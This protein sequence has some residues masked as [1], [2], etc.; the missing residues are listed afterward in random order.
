MRTETG[1]NRRVSVL[2][3]TKITAVVVAAAALAMALAAV[4]SYR[5]VSDLVG[6]ELERGL[7]DRMH[8]VHTLVVA[9][10]TPPPRRGIADQVV[11]ERGTVRR[12]T[13]SG[14]RIPVSAAALRVAAT[15]Q[16]GFVEDLV[17]GG[18]EYGVLT[19]PLPGGGA[20]MVA[21]SY[22][23]AARVD[24]AFLWRVTATTAA[25]LALS[26]LLSWFVVGRILRPVRRLARTTA[27]I[28]ATRDLTTELPPAGS[29]EVGQLTRSF[30]SMLTALRRSRDQQQRLV[31]DASHE[32]RTPLTS[33][34]GSAELLQRGRGRLAPEDEEQILTT[35]VT[36]T[37]ALDDLVRE[38][39]ELATDRYTDEPPEA[40]DL[41][42]L[43]EDSAL[44]HRARTGRTITVT[45]EDP[46]P[47]RARPRA[48]QRCV[49]NLI[50]NAVKF[51]PEGTPVALHVH[52]CR[53][54]VRDRGPGIAPDE[55]EAVFDRFH[56]GARTQA[57]PGS[58]LGLAIVHDSVTADGGTVFATDAADGGAEVGFVLPPAGPPHAPAVGRRLRRRS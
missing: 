9:G 44:R 35:L 21:Q 19:R 18:T 20:V 43:A 36:E 46:V 4:M 25:A 38:L 1:T 12:L 55:R 11:S 15:G 33:V 45:T 41:A 2:L 49:D 48:L 17:I 7:E 32:L 13:P 26:A 34:R 57:T 8:T 51:S 50:G 52:G 42:V 31:Q 14:P 54:S 3:R 22:E 27:R 30:A 24:D 29:D 23:G 16:G 39:V 58:G 37:A 47:V 28:T 10:L 40:V 6:E 5:G 53:L 56:R